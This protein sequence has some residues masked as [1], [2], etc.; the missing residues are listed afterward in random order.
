MKKPHASANIADPVLDA[1]VDISGHD[2]RKR[3][4]MYECRVNKT[5]ANNI[6]AELI[7][8]NIPNKKQLSEA[9]SG[10]YFI[11]VQASDGQLVLNAAGF[12]GK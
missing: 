9:R 2:W 8:L 11:T 10:R 6:E 3:G 1:L 4:D 5:H 7:D 12:Q